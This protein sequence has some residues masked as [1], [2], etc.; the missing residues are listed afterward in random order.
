MK[1]VPDHDHVINDIRQN[2]QTAMLYDLQ[3]IAS[4]EQMCCY[5][6]I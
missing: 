4:D 5:K 2:S 6:S 3:D 1:A